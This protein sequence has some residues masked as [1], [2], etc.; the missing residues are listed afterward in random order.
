M[1]FE[2]AAKFLQDGSIY[3]IFVWINML[4][5]DSEATAARSSSR[6]THLPSVEHFHDPDRALGAAVARSMGAPDKIA[7]DFH[8]VYGPGE[9]WGLEPPAPF[10]WFHQL[11]EEPWAGASHYRW[12]QAIYPAMRKALDDAVKLGAA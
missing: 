5:H 12:R 10:A 11:Q 1:A 4:L 3:L 2:A 9:Q 7:W 8:L 6:F